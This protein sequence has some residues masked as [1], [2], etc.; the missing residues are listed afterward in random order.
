MNDFKIV[1]I[2]GTIALSLACIIA[3]LLYTDQL[4]IL[5]VAIV[6]LASA[7]LMYSAK[8]AVRDGKLK[9]IFLDKWALFIFVMCFSLL[10]RE[11]SN[12]LFTD[13]SNIDIFTVLISMFTGISV[14]SIV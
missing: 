8:K 10:L 5:P 14:Y 1:E 7:A 6:N 2:I 13:T 3:C 11:L 4:I 9:K 12:F